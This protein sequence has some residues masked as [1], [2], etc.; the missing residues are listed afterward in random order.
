MIS[1]VG[2]GGRACDSCVT[3]LLLI[4]LQPEVKHTGLATLGRVNI[5]PDTSLKLETDV[6]SLE[7]QRE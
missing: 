4:M 6:S 1:V 2:E 3:I 7:D 5:D